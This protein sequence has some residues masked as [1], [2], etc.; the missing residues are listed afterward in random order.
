MR[1]E[2]PRPRNWLFHDLHCPSLVTLCRLRFTILPPPKDFGNHADRRCVG[3][4]P[5]L[6]PSG[7]IPVSP[8]PDHEKCGQANEQ[9]CHD[10]RQRMAGAMPIEHAPFKRPKQ[11]AQQD[12]P[13]RQLPVAH[14]RS[15]PAS[16]S[17]RH[18]WS[19]LRASAI[20]T[21]AFD[22]GLY[23]PNSQVASI[24]SCGMAFRGASQ[25]AIRAH[26]ASWNAE[27][28]HGR[29]SGYLPLVWL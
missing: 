8:V 4:L 9:P 11:K 27:H 14:R 23:Q 25:P 12:A 15:F 6:R 10:A 28:F 17:L 18:S 24:S 22:P 29:L 19:P 13:E 5:V 2:T 16:G 21:G 20:G 3:V 7:I 1:E 26:G